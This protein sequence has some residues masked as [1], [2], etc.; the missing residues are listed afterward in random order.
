MIS[1]GSTRFPIILPFSIDR[2]V[3]Q[4]TI[5]ILSA[6]LWLLVAVTGMQ[7]L[8]ELFRTGKT[9]GLKMSLH[10]FLKRVDGAYLGGL[11]QL[12]ITELNSRREKDR[13]FGDLK[14]HQYL[15]LHSDRFRTRRCLGEQ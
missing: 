2:S 13:R 14:A 4:T 5:Y 15:T 11:D 9:A 3:K 12:V 8:A 7:H 10:E 6:L 1:V